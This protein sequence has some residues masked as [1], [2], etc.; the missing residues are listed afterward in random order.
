MALVVTK[1]DLAE[2]RPFVAE[3][4]SLPTFIVSSHTGE[5][6]ESLR[7][8][9]GSRVGAGPRSLGSRLDAD[10]SS[11][12]TGLSRS[13]QGAGSVP[14]ELLA[15]DL[16]EALDA[17]DRIHGRSSPEDLLDRIFAGFV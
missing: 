4:L 8:F 9:L 6:L 14:E 16:R 3:D 10:L 15:V 5:G 1:A 13:V 11:A 12:E 7:A 17:L 2:A